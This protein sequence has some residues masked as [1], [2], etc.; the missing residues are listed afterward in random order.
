MPK[1]GTRNGNV[2]KTKDQLYIE[3]LKQKVSKGKLIICDGLNLKKILFF[4]FYL[5]LCDFWALFFENFNEA[6][7]SNTN[8]FFEL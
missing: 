4:Y 1:F 8:K 6:F 3:Y 2:Q 7:I 5:I